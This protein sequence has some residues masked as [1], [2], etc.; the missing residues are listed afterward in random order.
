MK[1][2][3]LARVVGVLFAV[4][5]F[6]LPVLAWVATVAT[7][8]LWFVDLGQRQ[9]FIVQVVSEILIGLAFGAVAFALVYVNARIARAMAPKAVLTSVGELPPQIEETLLKFR[10]GAARFLDRIVLW[11][12][13]AVAFV[14]ALSMAASWETIRL[15]VS[16]GMFGVVDPQFGR[17]VGFYVFTLPALRL[18]SDWLFGMLVFTAIVTL[19]VH[20]L[21]GAIQPWDRLRG[22]APHVKAHMSVLVAL[23]M[24][25]KAFDY[26]L[27]IYEL[28]FSPRGQVVGASYTDVHAQL[29]ALRILIGIA[30]LSAAILLLNIRQQGWRLPI[31]A[32]GV[33]LVA[34]VGVGGIYPALIQ[35]FRVAPN[36]V[37]AEAPYLERN[38][39]A[40]RA[41]FGLD[42]VETRTFGAKEDLTAQDVIDNR[43][44]L[45]NVRLWDPK[46]VMQSY[47]QLQVIRPY[48]D[49]LDVDVDRYQID[50]RERQV[51][52]SAREMDVNQLA[53]QAQTWV[54]RHLVYT[55]GYGVVM[56]PVNEADTRGLPDFIVR[57]IPPQTETGIDLTTPAIY[58]GEA[59]DDYA[60]VD[61]KGLDEFDYPSGEG[62]TNVTTRYK[63][64]AGV[65]IGGLFRRIAFALRFGA[66]QILFSQYISGDSRV[67][68]DRN[69]VDRVEKLA[70]WLWLDR[71]PYPV[72]VDGR[73]FWIMDGY[74][75]TNNYPY[76]E[77]FSGMNYMRN[78]VKVVVDAYEGTTTLYAFGEQDPI[79]E[80]WRGIFPTLVKDGDE[81]P[82]EIRSHLRYPEDL[83]TWQAEVYKNYHMLDPQVFYNKEDS[84]ELPGERTGTAMEP[85]YVLMRLPGEKAEDFQMILPFTARNRD[86]MIGW[87]SAS[88]D[89]DDYGRRVAYQFPR[90][91]VILGPEQVSARINQDETI[92]PQLT[93]WSQRGSSVLFGNML[94]IPLEDSVVYIQP[95]YLQAEQTAIPELTRVIVVYADKVEM[96]SDLESALLAVFG[97][98]APETTGTPEPGGAV[99]AAEAQ[100][101]YQEAIAAQRDG[102]WARY[103]ELID[104]LGR[105]LERLAGASGAATGS[106]EATTAQ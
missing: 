28:N 11:G 30:L 65:R 4:V 76:S 23:I 101:L 15:A 63:G 45:E 39:N 9:V 90:Q 33:W 42:T 104:E 100:S 87:M 68:F 83:F 27:Q 102:D 79:L 78:S 37:S 67:L 56:S 14:V 70:P 55:H 26:Y 7:D 81:M 82:E 97:Q 12:S 92:S 25:S 61:A 80:A 106:V 53:D 29:P 74:T 52:I 3:N 46:I 75:W 36:E 58:F 71:D 105:V 24:A 51:L 62:D 64:D 86:N 40:T 72:V 89:P 85:Y 43:D 91:R 88:S 22:V 1:E 44:T 47:R 38:I 94:V 66:S 69:I 34:V 19:I 21:D 35:Q 18:T 48:Y 95:L 20:V 103:G 16:G 99:T 98:Q 54:N 17:D 8:Y 49:F 41:A 10:A 50:G 13:L 6:G 96:A 73:I 57:D 31:V 84:W 59:T 93:L 60:I 5:V 77:R 2:R 32:V